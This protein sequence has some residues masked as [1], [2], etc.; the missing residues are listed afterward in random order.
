VRGG[1]KHMPHVSAHWG[2]IREGLLL[3]KPWLLHSEHVLPVSLHVCTCV[4]PRRRQLPALKLQQVKPVRRLDELHHY[5]S[6]G[7]MGLRV[8]SDFN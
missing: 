7:T 3:H 2:T 5:S 6:G 4:P 1:G 8:N